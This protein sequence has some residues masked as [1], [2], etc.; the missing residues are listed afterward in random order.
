M[1]RQNLVLWSM[2]VQ[3]LGGFAMMA[4]PLLALV[5]RHPAPS[6]IMFLLGFASIAS[7]S[8][9]HLI[10]LP[11]ELDASF[12]KALPILRDRQLL[13]PKDERAARRILKAAA[14]TYVAGSLAGLL[15]V[16]RWFRLMRR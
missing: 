11:V 10:T 2:K 9:V 6:L 1:M 5:T 14:Y 15:N 12:N 3:K 4:V 16:W 8:V 7:A 13:S